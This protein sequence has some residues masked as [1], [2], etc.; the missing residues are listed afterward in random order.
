MIKVNNKIDNNSKDN[1]IDKYFENINIDK[2]L[3]KL[4]EDKKRGINKNNKN[5]YYCNLLLN[6][7]NHTSHSK[8][9]YYQ[10]LYDFNTNPKDKNYKYFLFQKIN[11][12][13]DLLKNIE[14]TVNYYNFKEI[15]INQINFLNDENNYFYSYYYLLNNKTY[16]NPNEI[17]NIK[18]E[19]NHKIISLI[20]EKQKFFE[21]I[22]QNELIKITEI[23]KNTKNNQNSFEI[24][25][26]LYVINNLW[27]NKAITFLDNISKI[28]R[29]ENNNKFKQMFNLYQIY[30]SYFNNEKCI[31]VYPGPIDNYYISDF[32]DIWNDL[33]L[34]EENY[35][36]KKGLNLG[37]DYSLMKENDWKII[38]EVFGATNEIKRKINNLE[39]FKIKSII[40]DKRIIKNNK[41]NYLKPK[42]IQI[43]KNS[44]IKDFKDK[45]L[46]CI[47]YCF[48]SKKE[49]NIIIKEEKNL[50][51]KEKNEKEIEK[52]IN[53]N[54]I[55]ENKE[56]KMDINED[57]KI[58]NN[59]DDNIVKVNFFKLS[60]NNKY[61]LIE[62]LTSFI[63]EIPVYESI[64]IEKINLN[65]NN[66]LESLYNQYDKSK[67][68]L[69]IEIID[70]NSNQFFSQKTKNENGLY[71]CSSCKEYIPL[72]N[73]YNC[74]IC[75]MSFYCSQKCAESLIDNNHIL[76]HK[77][78]S[79][80]ITKKFDINKFLKLELN[81]SKFNDSLVGLKN[82][83]NTCFINSSLQ[84]LFN[85]YDL[86]KYFLSN[87]FIEEIS[88]KIEYGND[89]TISESYFQLLN[90]IKTTINSMINP[91]N[92][93][94]TF[95][96]KNKSLIK[97]QQ[98]AQE[99]LSIL[100]DELHEELN[101]IINKPYIELEEQKE[102]ESDFEASKRWWDYYKK[103]EDSI[104]IDLFH[105]QF[106]SK[107]T[108]LKCKKSSIT[109]DPFIFLGLPI[110]IAKEQFIIKFFFG[111]KCEYIG[112]NLDEKIRII[113]LKKK[114]IELIR[115]NNYKNEL[116][117]DEL[118]GI[119]EIVLIDKNKIVRNIINKYSKYHSFDDLSLLLNENENLEIVLY[120]KKLDQNYF[121]VY[122]YPIK[123]DEYDISNYPIALSAKLEMNFHEIIEENKEIILSLYTDLHRDDM[124][125]VGL[126]HKINNNWFFYFTNG[127]NSKEECPLC[128]NE[129]N[130]CYIKEGEKIG[131]LLK[132]I[133]KKNRDYGPVLF[134]I[135]NRQKNLVEKNNKYN[136]NFSNGLFNLSDCLK[137]FC[138]EELLNLDNSWYCNKCQKHRSAKKQ[139]RLYKLPIYL[140]IHLKKFKNNNG[141]FSSS[142]EKK[143]A[144][145][146][147]PINNLDLSQYI[148]VNQENKAKYDL[149]A[150]IQHHGE[151]NRGH[152]TSICKINDKWYLFNDDKYFLINNPINKDA[153]LLFYK[154]N[155]I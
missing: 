140:I 107:I 85:T 15:M 115:M 64:N 94:R 59:N 148:E 103:R 155:E 146:K 22:D 128:Q 28:N 102:N 145:I 78:L 42:Y 62:I 91:I 124:I 106:K 123:K 143:D 53:N 113:D 80:F 97:G 6:I 43:G 139:I 63:N 46:K 56:K 101:C 73:K 29:N 30:T 92:F 67:D 149:Y 4:R 51:N 66:P 86:T 136:K 121:N 118:Y 38:K 44:T 110:P 60:K 151:I 135:G 41:L 50:F 90:E 18:D 75:R 138:E 69:L 96:Q 77:Y 70:K 16:K 153:Y 93:I 133:N 37:Q 11:K 32:K 13:L 117:N 111:K 127:F 47:D 49:D 17:K 152:F 88:S 147:Y 144:Y 154:K 61:L 7:I 119:I 82:L 99:F 48:E 14:K 108:C 126:I 25:E 74:K 76:L 120:E 27:L 114:A 23:L 8:L 34:E 52:N 95:F 134:A 104:I 39:F 105:G 9:E 57:E 142:N 125:N 65:D 141:F 26:T 112:I 84:C 31:I 45:I 137:L 2:I 129:D 24:N 55:N 87:Y 20:E 79:E 5:E 54:D 81:T 36:I 89:T 3:N 150:V 109:Y 68:I 19:I 72:K 40:F 132:K 21:N 100:L 10:L 122:F 83:G 1:T 33:S 71:Q 116:S 130:F 58:D 131:Q 35:I 12:Y 98:D